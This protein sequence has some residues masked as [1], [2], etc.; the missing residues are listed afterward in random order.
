LLRDAG[1]KLFDFE[2]DLHKEVL[3]KNEKGTIVFKEGFG[4]TSGAR[5]DYELNGGKF[6]I[7]ETKD[8]SNQIVTRWTKKGINGIYAYAVHGVEVAKADFAET[9]EDIDE[10]HQFDYESHSVAVNVGEICI[11]KNDVMAVL[12]KVKE[13]KS[14]TKY[15]ADETAVKIQWQTMKT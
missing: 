7:K 14:G 1:I 12:V 3:T 4:P 9:F 13:V 8:S 6:I 10:I 2:K 15:G 5:F 11:F